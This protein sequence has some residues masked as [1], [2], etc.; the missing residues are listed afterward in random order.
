MKNDCQRLIVHKSFSKNFISSL[1]LYFLSVP[2]LYSQQAGHDPLETSAT[3]SFEEIYTQALN[4]APEILERDI[5]LQQAD[6]Y[7]AIADNWITQRPSLVVSY[8]DD[9][10]LGNIGQ[11]EF[12]YAIQ[13]QLRRPSERNN[14]RLLSES[15]K[16]QTQAWEQALQHYIA[17]RVRNILADIIEAETR[18]SLEQEATRNTE[19]LLNITNSLFNAGELARLDVM[20]VETLLLNQ[21]QL[22]METEAMLIDAERN[23]EA[24]TGIRIRPNYLYTE[25]LTELDDIE[26]SHPQLLMLQSQIKL[27]EANVLMSEASARGAP[28]LSLGASRQRADVFQSS[29]DSIALSL[30]I[31]FGAPNIVA[32]QTSA[33]RRQK[34]DIEVLY[35]NTLRQLD[36]AL[37]EVEHQL[38]LTTEAIV[39]AEEKSQ[40][41]EER[42]Q[43]SR[44]A[45]SQG[46]IT[47]TQV[48]QALQ[49]FMDAQ[50]QSQLLLLKQE[51]L[52][53]EFNQTIG[54]MP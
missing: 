14:S 3:I 39:L 44:T 50:Q 37:H 29:N 36:L 12:D 2:F 16:E 42:W 51:R 31:P 26:P 8:L 6:N 52:I 23:Y 13:L 5:R 53:T 47:M 41:S 54:V 11:R 7:E 10:S 20:Q 4:N 24:L 18:L 1:I 48:T 27:A 19:E 15:Y 9:N 30:S 46:E 34:A 28:T 22:V 32:S 21:R 45:F 35:Q 25:T 49:E 40:L 43:M 38:F 17:G 33:S